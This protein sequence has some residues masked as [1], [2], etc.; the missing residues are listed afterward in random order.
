M[1]TAFFSSSLTSVRPVKSSNAASSTMSIGRRLRRRNRSYATVSIHSAIMT[2]T[3]YNSSFFCVE[4]GHT[5]AAHSELHIS[6]SLSS[7][8]KATNLSYKHRLDSFVVFVTNLIGICDSRNLQPKCYTNSKFRRYNITL[9]HCR[10][11]FNIP[12]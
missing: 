2:C 4:D 9:T 5:C 7:N 1:T 8:P 11:T 10:S 12:L 3:L 6:S